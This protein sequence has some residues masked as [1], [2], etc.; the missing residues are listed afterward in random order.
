MLIRL[1]FP[2]FDR[3]MKAYSGRL[4]L[5][6]MDSRGEDRVNSELL[7]SISL[8][9]FLCRMRKT[10]PTAEDEGT[11]VPAAVGREE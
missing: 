11:L 2:T 9:V 5:G 4:S 8:R 10:R 6:H 1:D 7:I 3:P